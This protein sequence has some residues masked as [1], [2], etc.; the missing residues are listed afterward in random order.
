MEEAQ[1]HPSHYAS[2]VGVQL[3][4]D[5]LLMMG[6]GD[7]D[8]GGDPNFNGCVKGDQHCIC[9]RV[10]QGNDKVGEL[11]GVIL[12]NMGDYVCSVWRGQ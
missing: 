9:L 6:S 3:D 10:S 12:A 2:V 8:G 7:C 1:I 5:N 4:V 11:G